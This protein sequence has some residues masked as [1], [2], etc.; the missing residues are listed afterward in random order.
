M[1]EKYAT[2]NS[3]LLNCYMVRKHMDERQKKMEIKA[4]SILEFSLCTM[5]LW[6]AKRIEN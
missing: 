4:S 3:N 1:I 5:N 6:T 2:V